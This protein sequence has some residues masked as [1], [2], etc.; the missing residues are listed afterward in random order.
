MYI[1]MLKK[2]HDML[3][4]KKT[5]H[6]TINSK[7]AFFVSIALLEFDNLKRKGLKLLKVFSL[8][9]NIGLFF[10]SLTR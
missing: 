5:G 8:K 7:I 2:V 3:L 6:K 4:S 1:L 10:V 9:S